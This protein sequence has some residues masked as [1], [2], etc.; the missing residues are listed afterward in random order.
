MCNC[1]AQALTM[2]VSYLESAVR[3][4]VKAEGWLSRLV[5]RLGESVGWIWLLD[6]GSVG[7]FLDQRY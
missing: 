5:P 3:R 4:G 1:R 6:K 7:Y 2:T